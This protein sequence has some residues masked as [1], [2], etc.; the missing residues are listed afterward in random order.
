MT[1]ISDFVGGK[2]AVSAG[3]TGPDGGSAGTGLLAGW[4][5]TEFTPGGSIPLAGYTHLRDRM[6]THVRDPLF[7]RAVVF[8]PPQGRP[9]ALLSFDLL[10]ITEEIHQGMKSRLADTDLEVVCHATHTHSSVGGFWNSLLGRFF[11][12]SYRP[13]VQ[14]LLL[15]AAER[16]VR[17]AMADLAPVTVRS[18]GVTIPG[19]NGNRRD[20]DG[21]LDET[22]TVIR[23]QKP[24]SDAIMFSY[25]GHP[26]IAAER[27]HHAVSADFPGAAVAIIEKQFAF[28]MFVQGALGGVDVFFP[29]E[30]VSVDVNM[31][32]MASPIANAAVTLAHAAPKCADTLG[33]SRR[34]LD[35]GKPAVCVSYD[36]NKPFAD[37]FLNAAANLLVKPVPAVARIDGIRIGDSVIVG[38]PADLGIGLSLNVKQL[39]GDL[40]F[41]HVITASET[42][43]CIGYVHL[44]ADYEKTP[45]DKGEAIKMGRYENAMNFFG[46]Q[47]GLKF[48]DAALEVLTDLARVK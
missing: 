16:A 47:S 42:G 13:W 23:L 25:P 31:E 37:R 8:S 38:F 35:M 41:A 36:D 27:D 22:L 32:M 14:R 5:R 44:P 17:A 12:G 10:I 20:H 7:V 19:L 6:S 46:H 11:L 30:P 24:E 18:A 26:V 45:A 4:G 39:A 2:G 21:P 40:G 43:G 15:D 28:A 48:R 9:V 33:F 1:S 34:E 29:A 3:G